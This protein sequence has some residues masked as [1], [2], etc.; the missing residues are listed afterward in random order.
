MK[1]AVPFGIRFVHFE[2]IWLIGNKNVLLAW[3]LH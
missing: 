2:L 3:H 1:G